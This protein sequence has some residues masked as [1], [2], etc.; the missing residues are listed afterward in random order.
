M[1]DSIY[2][3]EAQMCDPLLLHT[4][5]VATRVKE[6]PQELESQTCKDVQRGL[7]WAF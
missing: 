4:L 1:T 5:D 2:H 6:N 3:L 7:G